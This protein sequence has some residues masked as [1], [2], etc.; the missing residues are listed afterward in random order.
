M[1]IARFIP[2]DTMSRVIATAREQGGRRLTWSILSLNNCRKDMPGEPEKKINQMQEW[3]KALAVK[4]MNADANLKT[5]PD[6]PEATEK[7]W[8]DGDLQWILPEITN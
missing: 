6:D 1:H 5:V 4:L 2:A 7:I 3:G 8:H